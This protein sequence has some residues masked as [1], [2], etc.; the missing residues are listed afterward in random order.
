MRDSIHHGRVIH[1]QQ[2]TVV[3]DSMAYIYD[4]PACEYVMPS[5]TREGATALRVQHVRTTHPWMLNDLLWDESPLS[6][7]EV[8]SGGNRE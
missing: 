8:N 6:R 5:T 7:E 4:C 2:R 3:L 1:K